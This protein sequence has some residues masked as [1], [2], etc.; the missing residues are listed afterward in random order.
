[1]GTTDNPVDLDY[2]ANA[3][4]DEPVLVLRGRDRHASGLV[5]LWALLR[6]ADGDDAASIAEDLRCADTMDNWA[7]RLGRKRGESDKRFEAF[8][9]VAT[10]GLNEHLAG[11]Q[12]PCYCDK[13]RPWKLSGATGQ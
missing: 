1:M 12:S 11:F 9:I 6:H 5:R 7:C 4:S 3:E 2:Y 10:D 8:Y 13:C